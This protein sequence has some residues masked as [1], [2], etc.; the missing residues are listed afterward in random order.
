MNNEETK[1]LVEIET[2]LE[3]FMEGTNVY[4]NELSSSIKDLQTKI[5]QL[6]CDSRQVITESFC[7]QLKL[8]WGVMILV[9]GAVVSRFFK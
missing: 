4:R 6:P 8:V 9:I 5:N 1:K 2:K 3:M 7:N